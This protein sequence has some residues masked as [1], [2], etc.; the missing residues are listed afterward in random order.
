VKIGITR[1]DAPDA[2]LPH[3]DGRVRI[4]EDVASEKRQFRKHGGG[5][6]RMPVGWNQHTEPGRGQKPRDERPRLRKRPRP[7][8][9]AEV[10]CHPQEL[11][12]NGPAYKPRIWA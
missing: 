12:D 9:C 3:E 10:R 4:V 1:A 2:V 6:Q 11:K 7:W 8:H 5:D